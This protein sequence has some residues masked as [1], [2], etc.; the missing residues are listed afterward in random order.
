MCYIVVR[1]T[2]ADYEKWRP[3]YDGDDVRR[4]AAGETGVSFVYRDVDDPNTTTVLMEWDKPENAQKFAN[5]PA[6]AEVMKKAGVI[7]QPSLVSIVSKS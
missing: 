5:D 1:H 6:L 2:V 4:R 3:F 7:G